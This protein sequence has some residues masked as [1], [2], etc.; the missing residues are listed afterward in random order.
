MFSTYTNKLY[1]EI[2]VEL[3]GDFVFLFKGYSPH[4]SNKSIVSLFGRN[5]FVLLK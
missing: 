5:S 3:F 1:I 2:T 4:N